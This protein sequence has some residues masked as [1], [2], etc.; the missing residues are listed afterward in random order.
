MTAYSRAVGATLLL[1]ALGCLQPAHAGPYTDDLSK[2]L[3]SSTSKD[4]RA[5]LVTW[6]F[7]AASLHPA[8]KS[9][10]SVTPRQLDDANK[11]AGE[12]FMRL[13]TDSCK[14][15]TQQAMQYEGP[16]TIQASFQ[17][18]GQVAGQELFTSPE[19]SGAMAGLAKY[20][21]EAKLKELSQPK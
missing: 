4:D 16:N 10:A 11:K 14:S 17:V 3:V 19:V 2:C 20:I 15:Q 8:V 18:L 21:D 7:S 13:L 6:M 9:I 1:G 5:S 12:L